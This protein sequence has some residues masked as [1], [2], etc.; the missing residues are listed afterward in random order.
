MSFLHLLAQANSELVMFG[1]VAKMRRALPTLTGDGLSVICDHD[2]DGEPP[3]IVMVVDHFDSR[4]KVFL[5]NR[6]ANKQL[7]F[8]VYE[9]CT[10][11]WRGL[12]NAP[13]ELGIRVGEFPGRILRDSAVFF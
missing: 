10:D 1:L 11:A 8:F 7:E 13:L 9:S 6:Y 4:F 2:E 12:E 5:M 3:V